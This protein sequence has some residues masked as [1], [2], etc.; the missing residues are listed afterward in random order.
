MKSQNL[1][2]ENRRIEIVYQDNQPQLLIDGRPI[3]YGQLPG[4]LYFLHEYAYDW[5]EDLV[6]VARRYI[7]YQR[8]VEEIRQER[9]LERGGN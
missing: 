9:E 6:E 1:E 7:D 2:Y 3:R 4:G 5:S 8:R